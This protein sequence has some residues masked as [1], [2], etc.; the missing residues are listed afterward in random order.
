M[1]KYT[2]FS[3]VHMM[4]VWSSGVGVYDRNAAQILKNQMLLQS[5]PSQWDR[6]HLGHAG[7][8]ID[9]AS[10]PDEICVG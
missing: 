5:E 9:T 10:H 8:R 1:I 6:P 2:I 3:P 4:Y 7:I